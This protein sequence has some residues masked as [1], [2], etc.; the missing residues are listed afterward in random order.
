MIRVFLLAILLAAPA[1]RLLAQLGVPLDVRLF[2]P[3]LGA[4]YEIDVT[5]SD[6]HADG[7][8]SVS[9][10]KSGVQ[11]TFSQTKARVTSNARL[12]A[13]LKPGAR[14]RVP[15][16]V[17]DLLG[18]ETA[19]A[20]VRSEAGVPFHQLRSLPL[21][22]A[23]V[24]DQGIGEQTYSIILQ[25]PNGQ[26]HHLH[27][28]FHT[29]DVRT[30]AM[31]LARGRWFEFPTALDDALLTKEQRSKRAQPRDAAT[32]VL[33]RY[34]GEWSGVDGGPPAKK[35]RMSCHARPDGSGIWR[36]IHI[37]NGT[38]DLPPLTMIVE[39]DDQR[40]AYVIRYPESNS[41]TSLHGRWDERTQTFTRTSLDLHNDYI[42]T[43]TFTRDD[44]IEWKATTQDADG[45]ITA[46]V[47][48]HYDR[49]SLPP[50]EDM[51]A[52]EFTR[53]KDRMPPSK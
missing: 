4:P 2:L 53:I 3:M 41:R 52:P 15:Q 10:R 48:G 30:V 25:Q 7:S 43:T 18:M 11:T 51:P 39:H 8:L 13:Q 47:S 27:G 36:T 26:L 40:Q 12:A 6:I 50:S 20:A 17:I 32:A 46:T 45:K 23:V 34:L 29:P 49:I 1:S 35:V 5:Q 9:Y 33:Q 21:F 37:D 19:L 44:R 16:C 22:E 14:Y 24:L 42:Y 31:F 38:N 28:T